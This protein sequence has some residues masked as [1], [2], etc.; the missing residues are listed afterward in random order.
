MSDALALPVLVP[1]F[2]AVLAVP[3]TGR[4]RLQDALS[5]ASGA[6]VLA[7]A[8]W[9]AAR[10]AGP[11]ILVLRL[12]GWDP[13][14]GVVWVA[15]ALSGLMLVL[16]ALTSLA[17]L[18]HAPASLRG[19]GESRYLHPLHH[20]MMAGVN[21]AFVTGDYFNLFVFFEVLL[22]ASFALIS[23]GA[24]PRQLR[25]VF[26]YVLVNLVASFSLLGGVGALY[27][28]AG[29]VNMAELSRRAAEG[30]LPGAFWA[31]AALVL[32]VFAVKAA[33]AP[34]FLWLPDAYPEAPIPVNAAFS[35]LLTKVGVYALYR[36]IP[37]LPGPERGQLQ[38]LLL[39]A[40]GATMLIGVVG[41]LG[42]S[43][44]RGVLSFHIVSQ[45]GYMI[46]GLAVLTPLS[47]AAGLFFLA[48]QVPTKL[49]LFLAGGVA[50][51][52][53]GSGEIGA[54]RGLART[55]PALAVG[56][57][58]PALA[59]SGL[60]P[61]SG[62]WGK[63]FLLIA[64][65]RAGA[66]AT[67]TIALGVSFLTLA[68]MLKIWV[69]TFWGAPE[70]QRAPALGRDGRMLSATLGVALIPVM[71]G[72]LAAPL[73]TYAERTAARL[74]DVTPYL[75]AVLGPTDAPKPSLPEG[76]PPE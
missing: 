50:E 31:A 55:H 4:P 46:F 6:A 35:G 9:I 36:S 26:P 7:V 66:W 52:V 28:T 30:A 12:G 8:L 5:I 58:V 32:L 60:P 54:V 22:L 41:A 23:L 2:T 29:T 11:E 64:G 57:F 71:L 38:P 16:A 69:A 45:I 33:L 3:L 21:G 68:S 62:F 56:F 15:D 65:Y 40:A 1:L 74:L 72:L 47:L 18:V 63:L 67:A 42:R 27:G 19:E 24:R 14:V 59:L 39:A 75:E 37:L 20:F 76:A 73:F 61:L 17:T 43:H 44:I 51:R 13:R 25:A 49:A 34:V 70:G 48:H 53:G 10:A